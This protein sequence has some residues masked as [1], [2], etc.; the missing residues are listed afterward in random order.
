M[1]TLYFTI[2]DLGTKEFYVEPANE[3]GYDWDSN[4]RY[5]EIGSIQ[6]DGGMVSIERLRKALDEFESKGANYVNLDYHCDHNEVEVTGV[7][8][9]TSTEKEIEDFI[10]AQEEKKEK[11]KADA[12]AKLQA[13]IDRIKNI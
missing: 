7:V 3:N 11:Q 13:E 10:K 12:I 5:E 8:Y 9:R 1:A 2:Q 4:D 6:R